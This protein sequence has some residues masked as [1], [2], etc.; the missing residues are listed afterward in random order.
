METK[1]NGAVG[2]VFCSK[3]GDSI[4]EDSLFCPECGAE[5]R[6]GHAPPASTVTPDESGGVSIALLVLSIII[7]IAGLVI[8]LVFRRSS[9]PPKRHAGNVYLWTA[10]AAFVLGVIMVW[11]TVPTEDEYYLGWL[12]RR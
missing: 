4:P 6:S 3:C 11:S 1:R 2:H 8:G 10:I 9:S 12:V 5:L 7:P